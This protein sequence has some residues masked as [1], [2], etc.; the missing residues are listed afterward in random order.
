MESNDDCKLC[1][2]LCV[3]TNKNHETK[4]SVSTG[5]IFSVKCKYMVEY[6]VK[7]IYYKLLDRLSVSST[8]IR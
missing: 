4:R 5:S 1:V 2:L 6:I 3:Y 8:S 7:C